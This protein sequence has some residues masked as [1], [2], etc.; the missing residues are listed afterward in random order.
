MAKEKY[1]LAFYREVIREH[2]DDFI[3]LITEKEDHFKQLL[4]SLRTIL[5]KENREPISRIERKVAGTERQC[6]QLLDL[7][8]E[9]R[10]LYKYNTK[11]VKKLRQWNSAD[12]PLFGQLCDLMET[13]KQDE[14]VDEAIKKILENNP[15]FMDELI[16]RLKGDR[17]AS[18]VIVTNLFQFESKWKKPRDL[19]DIVLH[20]CLKT[21]DHAEDDS[22][23]HSSMYLRAFC[24]AV[25]QRDAPLNCRDAITH[26]FDEKFDRH[27]VN[28]LEMEAIVYDQIADIQNTFAVDQRMKNSTEVGDS[29]IQAGI[30]GVDEGNQFDVD[31]KFGTFLR[32]LG[33][34]NEFESKIEAISLLKN[35]GNVAFY[36]LL[37][38]P[39]CQLMLLEKKK[40]AFR[41]TQIS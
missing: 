31:R 14:E 34:I 33:G 16:E 26:F 32:V 30:I 29:L 37:L 4:S 13:Q 21:E 24:R 38:P 1:S 20:Y 22:Q 6:E 23:S 3:K 40:E 7:V 19:A 8:L 11:V 25:L 5:S 36:D 9:S 2:K 35:T 10:P 17:L 15:T 27:V 39:H 12:A 28:F 41:G 18:K